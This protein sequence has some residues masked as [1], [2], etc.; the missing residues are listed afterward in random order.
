AVLGYLEKR[1]YTLLEK[2]YQTRA[3]EID[4]IA[5]EGEA[6]VFIEV[7]M[8]GGDRF[9]TGAEAV[10]TRKRERMIA[11]ARN[12]LAA[13]AEERDCRFDV[14]A[15]DESGSSSGTHLQHFEDA[16]GLTDG[17]LD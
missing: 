14:I 2:N 11:A 6:I 5:R 4:L 9:G 17:W 12:Y 1:G 7:K 8:R 13:L 3:G 10:D 16:F 15:L